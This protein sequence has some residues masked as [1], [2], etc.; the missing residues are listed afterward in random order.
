MTAHHTCSIGTFIAI[1]ISLL[2]L[3]SVA[4]A[5]EKLPADQLPAIAE[6]PDPFLLKDGS[7]VKTPQEWAK[8]RE[9][10]KE[11]VL[12]YE[13]GHLPPPSEVKAQLVSSR[14]E[15]VSGGA[16]SQI[17]LRVGPHGEIPV[18]MVVTAPPGSGPFPVI[19]KGDLC[20]GRVKPDIVANVI[21]HGYLLAEFDRTDLAPDK[22]NAEGGIRPLYPDVD[23]S[24]LGAWAW[25]FHRSLDYLLTRA[26][27][28]PK[29]IVYTGHS[30][31]GKACLLAGATDDRV[32]LVAPNGS[33]C[34]G[35]GCYRFQAP[36]SEQISDIL[37]NFPYWFQADFSQFIGKVDRL[38]IDQHTVK[39][40]VAPRALYTTDSQ[41]DLWANP[42]GTQLTYLA[43]KEVYKFLGVPE[44]IGLHYR[45][46]KH[47]QNEE[48]FQALLAFADHLFKG[49]GSP[50]SFEQLP[51]TDAP[52]AFNW[53]APK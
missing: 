8:H 44:K 10:L 7:R 51:Y 3:S 29:R 21:K 27:V 50:Q 31:G 28:D 17:E 16:E 49:T 43:A 25:G 47:E 37:K 5:M 13:Y 18:K 24:T 15:P 6:L 52:K 30:R 34:G 41:G 19:L 22:K 46:G 45:Q 39:A 11:L 38:P 36:K 2:L 20:W 33:G 32:A 1:G 12:T 4:R 40:L 14:T 9:E 42:Q 53:S 23:M 35:A 26:D 48:D